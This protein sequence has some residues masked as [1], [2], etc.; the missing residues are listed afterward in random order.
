MWANRENNRFFGGVA[1]SEVI[2][3]DI[4]IYC[5]AV[6]GPKMRNVEYYNTY[7]NK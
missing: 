6:D 2:T 1:L 5:A 7:Y 4:Q 3:K